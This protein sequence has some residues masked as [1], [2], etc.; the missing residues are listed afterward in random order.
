MDLKE[1]LQ[2]REEPEPLAGRLE[3]GD[4]EALI[5]LLP[6]RDD[7]LRYCSF[8]V[9]QARSRTHPDVYP[10]WERFA[11]M[12]EHPNSY[13]RNLGLRLT[14]ENVRWD[15][16]KR[17]SGLFPRWMELCRDEK[18]VTCRQALQSIPAWAPF[19]PEL[20][21]DAAH[22]LVG[23]DLSTVRES[24]R[25]LVLTDVLEALLALRPFFSSPETEAYA[26]SALEGGLLDRKTKKRLSESWAN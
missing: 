11:A 26:A 7:S 25:K 2:S 5:A 12:L 23:L 1:L 19:A 14:A 6:D 4:V 17:F 10:Y 21:K 13:Q 8:L 15:T 16:E 18:P 20:A 3:P 24:M 9:L 22:F